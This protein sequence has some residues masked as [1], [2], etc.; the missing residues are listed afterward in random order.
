MD[1]GLQGKSAIVTGSSRGIGKAIAIALSREGC[2]V[3]MCARGAETLAQA[4]GEVAAAGSKAHSVV[5]DVTKAEDV[6]RVI[7][8]T[9]GAFGGVDV[10]VNNAG[11]AVAGD[12]DAAWLNAYEMNLLAAVR[13]SRLVVPLM[14]E[15]GGGSIVH[16]TSIWGRESGGGAP[17]NAMKA[18]M[19]SHAKAL[20]NQLARDNIRVLSIAPGSIIFPG[21]GWERATQANPEGMKQ[22]VAANIPMGRFG[23][24]E[25]VADVVAF[26]VSERGGWVTGA[27]VTVDGGQS[28][29]NI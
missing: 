8:E 10:L 9:V 20:S 11:G 25:A 28:K 13:F 26:L 19:T 21:G 3:A 4:R 7:R 12:D 1:L 2:N 5:A 16:I 18:A 22:F 24:P 17:Y 14:R 29:S 23:S 6:E 15:R 27:S